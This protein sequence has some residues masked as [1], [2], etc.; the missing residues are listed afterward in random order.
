[1]TPRTT[2]ED[3]ESAFQEIKE[4]PDRTT[5]IVVAT[6]LESVLEDAILTRLRPMS[7]AHRKLLFEGEA[8]FAGFAAKI[9]LGFSLGLYGQQTKTDLDQIRRIRNE[10]AHY[11]GR[12]FEHPVIS[13]SCASMTDYRKQTE[14]DP[15]WSPVLKALLEYGEN[16]RRYVGAAMHFISGLLKEMGRVHHPADPIA[17]P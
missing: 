11:L 13:K 10:F 15:T 12:N 2:V 17:L 7:N 9:N 3:L 8:G 5:A 14:V 6:L 16:R 4:A 1:M